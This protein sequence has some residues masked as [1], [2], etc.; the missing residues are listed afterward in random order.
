MGPPRRTEMREKEM[1]EIDLLPN[2]YG[3]PLP[4]GA[5]AVDGDFV[6]EICLAGPSHIP[7]VTFPQSPLLTQRIDQIQQSFRSGSAVPGQGLIVQSHL[8]TRYRDHARHE[9]IITP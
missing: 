4:N 2:N 5:A 7:S 1:G 9:N 3:L 8:A 6:D